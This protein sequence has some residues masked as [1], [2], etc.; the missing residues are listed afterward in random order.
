MR[1]LPKSGDILFTIRIHLDPLE[2]L[3]NMPEGAKLAEAIEAQLGVLSVDEINYRGFVGERE[4]L[5]ARLRQIAALHS[6]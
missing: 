4:R 6:V 3:E 5:S 1:K 2:V